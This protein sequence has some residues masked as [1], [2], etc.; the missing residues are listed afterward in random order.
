VADLYTQNNKAG[1]AQLTGKAA[2]AYQTE[3][4]KKLQNMFSYM[5]RKFHDIETI[6]IVAPDAR[7]NDKMNQ[8]VLPEPTWIELIKS[9]QNFAVH[10]NTGTPY[11]KHM[12]TIL[13]GDINRAKGLTNSLLNQHICKMRIVHLGQDVL[14][15]FSGNK[16]QEYTSDLDTPDSESDEAVPIKKP[17]SKLQ[18]S[19]AASWY[20]SD[21]EPGNSSPRR[22]AVA[23]KSSDG[24]LPE[25]KQSKPT[26]SST[27]RH[28]D[29]VDFGK[30]KKGHKHK[31]TPQAEIAASFG[32]YV[33]LVKKQRADA[34][35]KQRVPKELFNDVMTLYPQHDEYVCL[36]VASY[37][38][39]HKMFYCYYQDAGEQQRRAVIHAGY[40]ELATTTNLT[41]LEV[42]D[43]TLDV[44]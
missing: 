15:V 44:L 33:S 37:I 19:M 17:A 3:T 35:N 41:N 8:L 34:E 2:K 24:I 20:D 40:T 27:S 39:R 23:G 25:C 38:H 10:R 22:A 21:E 1:E 12:F 28:N 6:R 26:S 14:R 7:W 36:L 29:L 18:S 43:P 9:H 42:A 30:P 5:S 16:H 13:N 32:E 11:Y 31:R 4:K